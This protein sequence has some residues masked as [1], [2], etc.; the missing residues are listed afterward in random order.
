MIA[1]DIFAE[2]F[3]LD[4]QDRERAGRAAGAAKALYRAAGG[5]AVPGPA[6]FIDAALSV[7]DAIGAYARNRQAKEI[8]QQLEI[9]GETLSR[10][11]IQLHERREIDRIVDQARLRQQLVATRD[12]LERE[13]RSFEMREVEFFQLANQVKKLGSRISEQRLQAP[14]NCAPLLKLEDVYYRLFDL[15]LASAADHLGE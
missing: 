10:L 13:R 4:D 14:P 9:E 11:L 6:V 12:R 1:V 8:T 5:K 3:D 7:L 2:V 15:V